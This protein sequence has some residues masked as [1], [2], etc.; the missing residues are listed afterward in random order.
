M[1][2]LLH[3]S[4]Q[5]C[6][7]WACVFSHLH[8]LLPTAPSPSQPALHPNPPSALF[9]VFFSPLLPRSILSLLCFLSVPPA[10]TVSFPFS[11]YRACKAQELIYVSAEVQPS[12]VCCCCRCSC[13]IYQV[14]PELEEEGRLGVGVGWGGWFT[15]RRA[16]FIFVMQCIDTLTQK[17]YIHRPLPPTYSH[18]S[19]RLN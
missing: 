11:P 5:S 18:L 7:S 1:A 19:S 2:A 12:G 15:A 10:L 6:G 9:P 8:H 16:P 13:L 4:A 14:E 17:L 3:F